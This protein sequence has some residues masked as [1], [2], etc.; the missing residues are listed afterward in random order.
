[1]AEKEEFWGCVKGQ[2]VKKMRRS[3]TNRWRRKWDKKE[4]VYEKEV[5]AI[6]QIP[7]SRNRVYT[8]PPIGGR[9]VS[10][11]LMIAYF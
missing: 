10:Q 7:S 11:E 2:I 5:E 9:M 6:D 4:G 1:M 8:R 3:K